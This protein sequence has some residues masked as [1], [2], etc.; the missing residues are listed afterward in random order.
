MTRLEKDVRFYDEI[1]H[2]NN[3]IICCDNGKNDVYHYILLICTAIKHKKTSISDQLVLVFT[4][5]H[6]AKLGSTNDKYRNTPS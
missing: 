1:K 5:D 3:D 4:P 2:I 6:K